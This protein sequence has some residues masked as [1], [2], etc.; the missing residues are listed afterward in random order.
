MQH[1][2]LAG[3]Q[4]G[5]SAEGIDLNQ[6]MEKP[7]FSQDTLPARDMPVDRWAQKDVL[8]TMLNMSLRRSTPVWSIPVELL[9]MMMYPSW[10]WRET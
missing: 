9:R 2:A 10:T 1:L 8:E 4:G 6:R 3:N 5:V 7:R